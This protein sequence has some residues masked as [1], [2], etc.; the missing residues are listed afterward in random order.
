MKR[1][2][3][4]RRGEFQWRKISLKPSIRSFG[5]AKK[6]AFALFD[7]R[8]QRPIDPV[9][10]LD[11][12][13]L[14]SRLRKPRTTNRTT[15]AFDEGEDESS[16]P[17]GFDKTH[18]PVRLYLREMGAVP[19]AESRGRNRNCAADRTRPDQ[20]T[21]HAFALPSDHSGDRLRSAKTLRSGA[22]RTRAMCCSCNDPLPSD[23]TWEAGADGTLYRV[24]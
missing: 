8:C 11:E 6:G 20:N 5:S 23:E 3:R 12:L 17:E 15:G 13:P 18:D 16:K 24:R 9:S 1:N 4:R 19:P 10:D 21:A 2:S 22:I 7:R 14:D